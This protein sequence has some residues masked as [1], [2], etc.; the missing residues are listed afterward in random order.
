M[1]VVKANAYGHGLIE[2]SRAAAAAGV[3]RLC[4][5]R[6]EEALRIR[7]AGMD[8]PILVMGHTMADKVNDAINN[9]ISLAVQSEAVAIEFNTRAVEMNG[10]L[11][12]HAKIDTGMGRLGVMPEDGV[13][14]GNLINNLKGLDFEGLFT[15][16]ASADD[17]EKSTTHEQIVKFNSVIDGLA[18][19]GIRPEIIHA[20]N[21]AASLYFP[22][23]WYDAIRPG[24]AIYGL[25]PAPEAP[26]PLDFEKAL[27][28]KCRISSVK[29]F[30]AGTGIGYNHRYITS[31]PQRIAAASAGYADGLRRRLGNIALIDG[32]RV[33]Q[34]G[35]MCMDQ[36][37]W[38]LDDKANVKVGDEMV[39]IG[40]QKSES[41]T[42]EELGALWSSNN[43]DVVCGLTDRVPRFYIDK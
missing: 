18:E 1:A 20:A 21:S 6:I 12:V 42:A 37:M 23:A 19:S 8:V 39:L 17:P 22:D 29:T 25:D 24:I 7:D 33:D 41:L 27:T 31:K 36:S 5:A 13:R 30:P 16:F 14:F 32:K 2:V 43:Y 35:G 28:W 11:A 15:H 38:I 4:V 40:K 3:G 26:V 9:M 10:K 34:A